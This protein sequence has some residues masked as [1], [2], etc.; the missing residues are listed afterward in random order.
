MTSLASCRVV[1]WHTRCCRLLSSVPIELVPLP[2][3]KSVV[4]SGEWNSDSG[5]CDL[6]P[7]WFK[8]NPKFVIR[9]QGRTQLTITLTRLPGQWRRGTSL[10]K[11]IGFYILAASD[12]DGNVQQPH[13]SIRAE[14]TF[15]PLAKSTLQYE[16]MPTE[17]TPAFILVPCT[18][19]PG[20][21]GGFQ[22]S[23]TSSTSSF[24]VHSLQL[25]DTSPKPPGDIKSDELSVAIPTEAQD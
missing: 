24:E 19:G 10:D 8:R 1:K 4:L 23:I 16:L 20:C 12:V 14:S 21:K 9:P 5:G 3:S 22:L 13:K 25:H 6:H 15:L 17:R 7:F 18:Y 2:E 11:M